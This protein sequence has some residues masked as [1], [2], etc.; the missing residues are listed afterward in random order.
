MRHFAQGRPHNEHLVENGS[1]QGWCSQTHKQHG[2]VPGAGA[3]HTV[4]AQQTL[5]SS[6]AP[7]GLE[8]AHRAHLRL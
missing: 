3:R 5:A 2:T 6:A 8:G 4:G 1:Q 7:S